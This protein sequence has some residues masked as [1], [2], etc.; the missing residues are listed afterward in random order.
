[1]PCADLQGMTSETTSDATRG[2]PLA[3]RAQKR[4]A[5][6]EAAL[7]KL[8]ETE[9]RARNDIGL[10]ISTVDSL[11]TGDLEHLP[12]VVAADLDRWLERTK[13][14]AETTTVR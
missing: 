12:D 5:E 14:L 3:L 4:K 2:Q 6:L 10:A 7:D 13:H 11:L 1:M 8:S 9:R